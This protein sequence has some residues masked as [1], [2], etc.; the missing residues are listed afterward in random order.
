MQTKYT[1]STVDEIVYFAV[2]RMSDMAPILRRRPGDY[3]PRLPK[4]NAG[5]S[6]SGYGQ[7]LSIRNVVPVPPSAKG[8]NTSNVSS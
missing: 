1:N 4:G 8:K 5:S 3:L 2:Q 7:Q 6:S